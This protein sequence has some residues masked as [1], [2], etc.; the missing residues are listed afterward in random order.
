MRYLLDTHALIWFRTGS[1]NLSPVARDLI[2][3]SENELY[4]SLAGV[5]EL[6]IKIRLGRVSIEMPL[7]D[8]IEQGLAASSIELLGVEPRHVY[9]IAELP[10]H[11]RD[12]FDRLIASQCL[13]DGLRLISADEAIDAYGVTRLW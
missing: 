7:A 2:E 5:W 8:Y 11:H 13:V 12:P 10:L 3:D 6:A 9:P 1:L 4:F